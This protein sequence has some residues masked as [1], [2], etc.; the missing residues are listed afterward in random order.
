M[1]EGFSEDLRKSDET[2][3]ILSILTTG[4]TGGV[5][6]WGYILEKVGLQM[7][8]LRHTRA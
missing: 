5:T 2:D 3:N 7:W 1:F 4:V 6:N 8:G